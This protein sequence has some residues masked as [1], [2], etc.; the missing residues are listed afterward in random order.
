MI[1]SVTDTRSSFLI[2]DRLVRSLVIRTEYVTYVDII[3]W[4]RATSGQR[5]QFSV[6]GGKF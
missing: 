4:V 3:M 2:R 1:Q 5:Y 6:G